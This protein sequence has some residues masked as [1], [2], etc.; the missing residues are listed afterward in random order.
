MATFA[1]PDMFTNPFGEPSSSRSA[2]S[3]SASA[4]PGHNHIQQPVANAQDPLDL[5]DD[6]QFTTLF[7]RALYNYEAQDSSALSFKQDDIIEV[8]SQQPTGWWDGLLGE[9]RG[10]FPSN[11]VEIISDEEAEAAFSGSEMAPGTDFSTTPGDN[12]ADNSMVNMSEALM[13]GSQSE[14]EEW[15]DNEVAYRSG[16]RATTNGTAPPTNG[17]SGTSKAQPGDYWMPEITPDN[18]VSNDSRFRGSF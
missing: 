14:N 13:R 9:E 11:Y 12:T 5:V 3:A 18:Q 8:L 10:W 6:G 1:H 7:C 17:T 2:S 4:Y 16:S 15:L